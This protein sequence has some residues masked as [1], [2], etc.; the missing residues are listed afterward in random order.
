M[1]ETARGKTGVL[2]GLAVAAIA[3]LPA[4]SASAG[5]QS[6][7]AS[8]LSHE[9]ASAGSASGAYVYD[10]STNGDSAGV[11]PTGYGTGAALTREVY[12]RVPDEQLWALK[13]GGHQQVGAWTLDYWGNFA[14]TS[15]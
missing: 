6:T 1:P 13:A 14:G 12:I 4:P 8:R 15:Q 2:P 11:G 3:L 10:I 7:L 9:L 5:A